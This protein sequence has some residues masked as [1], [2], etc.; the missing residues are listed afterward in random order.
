M[1]SICIPIYNRDVTALVRELVAQAESLN[2]GYEVLLLDDAS[3]VSYRKKNDSLRSLDKVAILVNDSNMG[4]SVCRNRLA[5]AARFPYLLFMDCDVSVTRTDYLKRYLDHLPAEIVVGGYEYSKDKPLG[6]NCLRWLYGTKREVVPAAK[7]RLHPND[8]FSTF[9]FVVA[10]SVFQKVRFDETLVGYGHEDTL[11]GLELK[12][13]GIVVRHIDNPL[14][15]DV[16]VTNERFLAQIENS[17]ENLRKIVRKMRNPEPLVR[18]VSLLKTFRNLKNRRLLG[19]YR[20]FFA[21]FHP[22]LKRNL[23]SAHPSLFL[24]D[25]YKLGYLCKVEKDDNCM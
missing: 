10:K 3:D 16:L 15:H 8:S 6:N 19:L 7:R 4:R 12:S 24:F 2:V 11:F 13:Q 1:L 23:L 21:V 25:L 14:R 5:E 22:L 18:S 9:N 17:I 20:F